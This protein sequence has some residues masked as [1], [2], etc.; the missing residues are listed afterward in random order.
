MEQPISDWSNHLCLLMEQVIESRK[1]LTVIILEESLRGHSRCRTQQINVG[2]KRG[3]KNEQGF[4]TY[5]H[6]WFVIVL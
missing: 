1:K 4:L 6:N 3:G 5:K 2:K